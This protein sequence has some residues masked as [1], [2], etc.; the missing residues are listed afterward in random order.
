MIQPDR[1]LLQTLNRTLSL[2]LQCIWLF[3]PSILFIGLTIWCFWSLDQGKD[4]VVAFTENPKARI[5]FFIAIGFWAYVTWYSSRVN[6]Y[7]KD[8]KTGDPSGLRSTFPRLLGLACFL[9]IELAALQSPVAAH[10]LKGRLAAGI[11]IAALLAFGLLDQFIADFSAGSPRK[12]RIIRRLFYALAALFVLFLALLLFDKVLSNDITEL[13]WSVFYLKLLYLLHTN[14]RR[15]TVEHEQPMA[16]LKASHPVDLLPRS[17]YSIM[18]FL[19][20]P[21]AELLY[22][23]CFNA[24]CAIALVVYLSEINSMDFAVHIGPFPSVILAFA[25]LL[26]FSNILTALSVKSAVNLHFIVFLFAFIIHSP[27]NHFV[28]TT[29]LPESAPRGVFLQ[30]PSVTQYFSRWIAD[31]MHDIDSSGKD[32]YPVYFVLSNGGA[33]RSAYWTAS[34]LGRL[35]DSSLVGGDPFSRHVFCLS[36][37]SGGGVG[38]ASFFSLLHHTQNMPVR[39]PCYEQSARNFLGRDFLSYTLVRLL[40]PDYFRFILHVG[41]GTDRAAALEESFEEQKTMTDSAACYPMDFGMTMDEAIPRPDAPATLPILCINSTRMQDG[42]PGV[43]TNIGI[44]GDAFDGRIDMLTLL[45]SSKT[46]R[47]STASI[48]GARFPYISP[49]GRIDERIPRNATSRR[50]RL[51][52]SCCTSN[53]FVDGGYFDNSG[54]GVVQEMIGSIMDYLRSVPD[55]QIRDA[56]KKL[57]FVVLHITNSP[58]GDPIIKRTRPISNDLFSPALTLFGA[59][60]MQTTVNDRRLENYITALK[61]DPQIGSAQYTPVSLYRDP[62]DPRDNHLRRENYSMNWFIS[63][64][65]RRSMDRRLKDQ[66]ML[67][68][69]IRSIKK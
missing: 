26:G 38:V 34:V 8:D 33:S 15:R 51:R 9:A 45:D 7:L 29:E 5:Y 12:E 65:V 54:A 22:F 68:D 46:M 49:A 27:E 62:Y 10:P 36:G 16:E 6:A 42:N 57:K 19:R 60:D 30:K 13:F 23:V 35:E 66:P 28:R 67:K 64:T 1:T 2:L 41:P 39:R 40:G 25:I 32:P 18:R 3:F 59:Y 11:F 20:I 21:E 4:L 31:R 52:D 43:V 17:V 47:L 48:L 50:S 58:M 56:A 61:R 69:L 14:L 24:L 37:T 55:Q 63:D 44:N 53:Y